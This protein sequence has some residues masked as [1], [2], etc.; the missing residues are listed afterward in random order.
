M[1]ISI[2]AKL[3]TLDNGLTVITKEIHA[4]P[5]ATVWACYKVGSRNERDGITGC[6]HWVEHMLFKGGKKFKK[7]DIF[8]QV[9]RA[10]GYNNGFTDNDLTVY[11]ETLP[12]ESVDIGLEIEADRMA[13]ASFNPQETESERTVIISEREGAENNPQFLLMEELFSAA[14]RVHPYRWMVI[15]HKCDLQ[16]MTRDDLYNYYRTYYGPNNAILLILG[17][18]STDQV[19]KKVENLFGPIASSAAP[20]AVRAIEPP[21]QGERR[22]RLHRPGTAAYLQAGFHIPAAGHE[23]IPAL[24]MLDAVLSGGK[25]ISLGSRTWMGRSSRLYRALV[26]TSLASSVDS[27]CPIPRD[28]SLLILWATARAGVEPQRVEEALLA[29]LERIANAPPSQEEME[30]ALRQMQAQAAYSADGVTA[31]AYLLAGF[32]CTAA[33]DYLDTLVASLSRVKAEEVQRVAA[34]YLKADNRTVGWFI[35]TNETPAGNAAKA[36]P[37]TAFRFMPF[38]EGRQSP[39]GSA[40]AIERFPLSSGGALLVSPNRNAPGVV[41][42]A[43]LAAGGTRES[44]EQAGLAN[45]TSRLVMRGTARHSYQETAESVESIGASLSFGASLEEA[46]GIAKCMSADVPH[47]LSTLA[48]CWREA[49][50]PE[51]EVE[52]VRSETITAIRQEKDDTRAA[53]EQ[54]FRR[55]LYPAGHP[56]GRKRLGEE[57]TLAAITRE[58]IADFHR[59]NFHPANMILV[60]VG[61]VDP[62]GVFEAAEKAFGGWKKDAPPVLSVPPLPGRSRLL[63]EIVPMMHKSQADIALGFPALA[64]KD[65]DFYAAHLA[66]LI[67]GRL[68]LMGRLGKNVRDEQGLAYYAFSAL[69][70]MKYG[71]HWII[72]AGVNPKNV[73]RAQKSIW[74]EAKRLAMQP[75]SQEELAEAKSNQIGS[76]ALQLETNEGVAAA[77]HQMEYHDLGLDYLARFPGIIRALS[78]KQLQEAARRCL[79]EES[80]VEVIVGPYGT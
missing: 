58:H 37:P 23:D 11:F 15:G 39:R 26:E 33:Y 12:A 47:L 30:K 79:K 44:D 31:Q 38:T 55:L 56:Y 76:L 3:T 7:G 78:E 59:A 10:G 60:V 70:A 53:A 73:D 52:K 41:I 1:S 20:P 34:A 17:D 75:V 21:Q 14:F 9:A 64:R 13:N 77:I 19:L 69:H 24:L 45:L 67:F 36:A 27:M 32:A 62:Q 48:E 18:F 28:P 22:V 29:E 57:E 54:R 61:D 74:E 40:P 42:R 35:P 51:K 80:G 50:F 46:H 65:P 43:S 72:Q 63:R 5:V 49:A 8:K 16:Q 68:G 66:C 25:F 71:G 6:S 2:G 4:S